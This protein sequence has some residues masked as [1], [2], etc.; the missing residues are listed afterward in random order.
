MYLLCLKKFFHE[1]K[2]FGEKSLDG[3]TWGVKKFFWENFGGGYEP[4]LG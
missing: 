2:N 3:K 4:E 1:A